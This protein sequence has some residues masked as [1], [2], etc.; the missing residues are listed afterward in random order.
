VST[1][2][3]LEPDDRGAATEAAATPPTPASADA[4]AAA[5]ADATPEAAAPLYVVGVGAS[6][7]GLEAIRELVK[8][9]P[10]R[11]GAAYV[12]VQHMSPQHSSLLTTLIARETALKVRDIEDG[13]RPEPDVVHVTPP[14]RDVTLEGGALRLMKPNP[15]VAAPKPSVDRFFISLAEGIGERA[16]GVVLSGTGSD[17]AYGVQAIR[18]VGGITIAQDDQTAKYDGMPLA[19]VETGCVDLVLSPMEIGVHLSKILAT[20]RDFDG[21]RGEQT[22]EHPMTALLQVLLARTRVDF[23]DYKPTTV[24]RRIERRMTALGIA[25]QDAYTTYCRAN[26]REVDALFK[27]LLISVTRFFRDP[28]E[29]AALK[30]L[31][32]RMVE[33][34]RDAPLRVWIP[35]CATGEEAYSIAILLAEALGGPADLTRERV[36]IFATDIDGDAL[37]VARRGRYNLAAV[38]DVP[39]AYVDRYFRKTQDAIEVLDVLKDVIMFSKHNVFQDPPFLNIDLLCCRNLLIYF[40]AQLQQ[41]VLSRFQYALRSEGL[42][43]LGTAETVAGAESMFRPEEGRAHIFRRR[44]GHEGAPRRPP[45]GFEGRM[46]RRGIVAAPGEARPA[47]TVERAMFD[48][49]ARAV[50]ADALLVTPDMRILRVYGD[51]GPYVTLNERSRLQMTAAVLREPLGSEA[52]T[53]VTLALR[54]GQPRRGLVHTIEDADL[55]VQIEVFPVAGAGLSESAALIALRGVRRTAADNRR[56]TPAETGERERI[57]TLEREVENT[58]EALQQTIEELETS[59]EELQ[60]LNEELQSTNEELQATNEELETSNEE[61]QSTN[62]ELVTV[63]EELQINAAELAAMTEDLAA[64]LQNIATPVLVVDEAL[65]ITRASAAAVDLFRVGARGQHVHLSQCA[66]PAGFPS[67]TEICDEALRLGQASRREIDTGDRLYI[68]S[69]APF[70][71]AHGRLR[72]ATM[73]FVET[74]VA[75]KLSQQLQA[76]LDGGPVL[77]LHMDLAG[78][79]LGLS[80]A[81]ARLI[82]VDRASALGRPAAGVLGAETAAKLAEADARFLASGRDSAPED[83]PEDV[84]LLDGRGVRRW[85]SFRRHRYRTGREGLDS[86]YRVGLD[87]TDNRREQA[88]LQRQNEQLLLAQEMAG[89]GYWAHDPA[90]GGLYWS[91][92]LYAIHGVDPAIYTPGLQSMLDFYHPEDRPHA[93]AAFRKA[94]DR[95]E[96]A[97]FRLRILTPAGETRTVDCRIKAHGAADGS[98]AYLIGVF[99]AV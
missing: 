71:D 68:L 67:L 35:G 40:G 53:L 92:T 30:R 50:G 55:A 80:A 41:R 64:V 66:A 36:Q 5:D 31:V 11:S 86:V 78:R 13:M 48:A 57:R 51:L 49:L 20:P 85:V 75:L 45:V 21:L 93:E 56:E 87:L 42:L 22:P 97:R 52:R 17:G 90:T 77:M 37:H 6:A 26:P 96:G 74:P 34:R 88:C 99:H 7:G 2:A 79:V 44:A 8:N 47:E 24:L 10:A 54:H 83:E 72:G 58:R 23:R 27:D 70:S 9:L 19:A 39:A 62:E 4:P 69:V 98:S 1:P 60:S 59:N 33:E 43:F 91:D 25:D 28:E 95:G 84:C 61:L 16:V 38:Y 14:N 89:V 73:V 82:G 15:S 18:E 81:M 76:V 46:P 12:I 63:N 94:L 29:F 3:A 65:Q 32:Q